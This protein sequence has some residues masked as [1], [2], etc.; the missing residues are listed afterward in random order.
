[1]S[2]TFRPYVPEQ[3]LL[4]PPDVR[5]WLPEGHLAHHISDL[6]DGL[7]LTAFYAPYE[8]WS[9]GPGDSV[10]G[11]RL[12][13]VCVC[14]VLLQAGGAAA[15]GKVALV[16][17]N[18]VYAAGGSLANPVNDAAAVGA[19]LRRLGF[20]VTSVENA[21]RRAM[22]DALRAFEDRSV[23]AAMALVFYAGHGLEMAGVNYLVPVDARLRRDTDVED[24][25]VRLDRVL[26]RMEG[27]RTRVVI[28]DACRNNPLVGAMQQT[29]EFRT[30]SRG[31]LGALD[32]SRLGR[33]TLV[34]YAARAGTM[35]EDGRGRRHSPYTAALLSYLEEPL[36]IG[37]LF[38]RVRAQVLEMTNG[39]QDPRAYD[40]LLG[41]HYLIGGPGTVDIGDPGTVDDPRRPGWVFRDC[42]ECP[43]LVV[44]P[45]GTFMMGSPA[46]E[47]RRNDN[48][49]PQHPV[50]L[51]S[52]AMGRTE[53]TRAEYA[54]FVTATGHGSGGGCRVYGGRLNT[55][56][57]AS[58]RE[59]G[60]SQG[61]GAIRWC[62]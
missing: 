8:C 60:F 2:T 5:E 9:D 49:G 19:A 23:G 57:A 54:A 56:D 40:A 27:A 44:I 4:L 22:L 47:E 58:W 18:G 61:G 20:A 31:S 30:F 39:T 55:D 59:P 26:A 36:E 11:W 10:A 33:E 21:D 50:T 41:E 3:S 14:L 17:G 29:S 1:M 51:R 7:D 42:D 62:A 6:V 35:A 28:L 13:F 15:A 43:E 46:S 25:T 34:A 48:E 24:E 32:E 52:F 45:A 38:R 53:V 16:I 12:G 37:L